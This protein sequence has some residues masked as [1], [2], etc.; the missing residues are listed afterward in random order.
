MYNALRK[1]QMAPLSVS[2]SER[3]MNVWEIPFAA[4]TICPTGGLSPLNSNYDVSGKANV[5]PL[6]GFTGL[7]E[8][9]IK[10]VMWRKTLKASGELFTEIATEEG[11]CWTFNMMNFRDLFEDNV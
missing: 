3:F 5:N 11:F 8:K 1:C 6:K 9:R 2:F 7:I 10:N 4:I